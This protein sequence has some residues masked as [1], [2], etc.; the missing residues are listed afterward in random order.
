MKKTFLL[1]NG[2]LGLSNLSARRQRVIVF[3][4]MTIL[5][6]CV[7]FQKPESAASKQGFKATG[8]KL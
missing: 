6:I 8:E 1:S 2:K 3:S 7:Q 4:T 5:L